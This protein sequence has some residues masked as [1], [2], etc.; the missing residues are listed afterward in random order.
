MREGEFHNVREAQEYC[1]RKYGIEVAEW[2]NHIRLRHEFGFDYEVSNLGNP[3]PY[4][5]TPPNAKIVMRLSPWGI[6]WPDGEETQTIRLSI[7]GTREGLE[8]L[9]AMLL[10]CAHSQQYDPEYTVDLERE[11]CVETNVPVRICTP[12]NLEYLRDSQYELHGEL[13]RK[14]SDGFPR[15]TFKGT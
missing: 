1:A 3:H 2:Q 8:H 7:C 4:P 15:V 6:C 9:A 5:V 11:E 13:I 10:V 12:G 14:P